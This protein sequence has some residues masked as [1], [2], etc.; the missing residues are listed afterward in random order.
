MDTEAVEALRKALNVNPFTS[1]AHEKL[2]QALIRLGQNDERPEECAPPRNR[3]GEARTIDNLRRASATDPS[4]YDGE[5]P[6][7]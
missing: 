3:A 7:H 6:R 2:G 5:Q 4:N 1:E